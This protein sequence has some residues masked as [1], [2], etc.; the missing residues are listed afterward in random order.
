MKWLKQERGNWFADPF[1]HS[2]AGRHH[3]FFEVFDYKTQRGVIGHADITDSFE[4]LHWETV[5]DTGVHLSYPQ[6]L[7]DEGNRFLIVEAPF[8]NEAALYRAEDFPA[9]GSSTRCCSTRFPRLT[10]RYSST[11]GA[12][13]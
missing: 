13:G 5:L 6:I 1:G 11:R 3:L 12:G 7:T 4:R 2:E 9:T 8:A 10:Q